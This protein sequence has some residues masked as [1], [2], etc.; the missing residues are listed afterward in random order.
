[1]TYVLFYQIDREFKVMSALYTKRF[2]V[3]KMI[4][5]CSDRNIIGTEFYLMEFIAVGCK[6]FYVL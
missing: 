5:F 4:H 2:P 6:G 1:M 3:P